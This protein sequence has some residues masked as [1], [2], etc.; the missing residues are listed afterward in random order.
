MQ[1]SNNTQGVLRILRVPMT[2]EGGPRERPQLRL[3]W[4]LANRALG[5]RHSVG[6]SYP[7]YIS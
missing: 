1:F 4:A 5:A 7:F 2:L 3:D 6:W